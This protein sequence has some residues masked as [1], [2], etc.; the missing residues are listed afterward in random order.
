MTEEITTY[1]IDEVIN[2]EQEARNQSET[3]QFCGKD[4]VFV[5]GLCDTCAKGHYE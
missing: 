2:S 4:D 3:C 5:G 1:E